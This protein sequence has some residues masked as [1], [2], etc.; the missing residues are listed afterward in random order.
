[1]FHNK[2]IETQLDSQIISCSNDSCD[3]KLLPW[4]VDSH[5][6]VCRNALFDCFLCDSPVSL[7]SLEEHIKT[8][9][10][11]TEWLEINDDRTDGT[12]TMV[13]NNLL[14][15]DNISV[16]LPETIGNVFIISGH[17]VLMLKWDDDVG[18]Y[19]TLVDCEQDGNTI[20]IHF[21]QTPNSNTSIKS[22]ILLT[23]ANTLSEIELFD[24]L[25]II[26]RDIKE[27]TLQL[28][29]EPEE[30]DGFSRFMSNLLVQN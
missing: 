19:V 6:A 26:P 14:F 28:E 2:F 10:C 8:G 15:S 7:A 5:A 11:D 9:C 23:A 25:S 1:L 29:K 20:D 12:S 13:V 16:T 17:L 27:I 21:K 22:S 4:S 18:Y 24:M 3:K 30:I